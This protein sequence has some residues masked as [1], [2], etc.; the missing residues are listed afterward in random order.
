[1]DNVDDQSWIRVY[2]CPANS[3]IGDSPEISVLSSKIPPFN[4]FWGDMK[5]FTAEDLRSYNGST[6][7]VYVAY[8][9]KVYD[10]SD[11]YLWEDGLHQD[12]HEAGH[13]L[14]RFLDEEAPHDANL[15]ESFPVVGE[16][17]ETESDDDDTQS[18]F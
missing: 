6:G 2:N 14:T 17:V 9:G 5:K 15:L 16:F 4:T 11:S 10:L 8:K 1:M 3:G 12:M 7:P 13:N 18:I